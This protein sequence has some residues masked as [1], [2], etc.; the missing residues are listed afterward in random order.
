[1]YAP[2]IPEL[3]FSIVWAVLFIVCTILNSCTKKGA[4]KIIFNVCLVICVL[5]DVILLFTAT[6]GVGASGY[7]NAEKIC[8][9]QRK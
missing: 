1:M 5:L 8:Y 7:D 6:V 2:Y 3:V 4:I 9:L